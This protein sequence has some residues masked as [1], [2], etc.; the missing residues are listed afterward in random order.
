MAL[1][2]KIYI[3]K[4]KLVFDIKIY[5]KTTSFLSQDKKRCHKMNLEYPGHRINDH[6]RTLNSTPFFFLDNGK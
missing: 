4:K 6:Y 5:E 3:F 2:F 1:N